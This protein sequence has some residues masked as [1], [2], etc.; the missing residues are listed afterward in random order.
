[1]N[2]WTIKEI[3]SAL[4]LKH[5]ENKILF[6]G[7]SIDS[8]TIKKGNLYIPLKGNNFDGHDFIENAFENGASA[9]LT[10]YYPKKNDSKKPLI[11][12]KNN[13][14][15]LIE[16]A[17]YSRKRIKN[18]ITVC[19]TGSSGKTTLKEWIYEI[20][21]TS[22]ISYCTIGNFNNEIG[23]PLSL[24]NMPKNTELCILELG[25]N[26]P[27][28]I[29]K[30]SK[31]ANPN[32]SI[33]TNIGSAHAENFKKLEEIAFEKSEIFTFL[34]EKSI[35]IIPRDSEF[36]DLINKKALKK[37]KKVFSFGKKDNCHFKIEDNLESK[38]SEFRIFN[39]FIK[40]ENKSSFIN[41]ERNIVVILG[42][43][44]LLKIRIND[45][46]PKIKNLKPIKGRGQI[47]KIKFNDKLFN[48]I[49]ESYN[50]NPESLNSALENLANFNSG[51]SRKICIIGDM[52]E[53]GKLSAKHHLNVV[54]TIMKIKP[55]IV[56]TVGNHTRMIF[57]NLPDYFQKFHYQDYK[58]VFRK[59]LSLI[60]NNDIIMIKGSNS[61]N[62]HL[63]TKKLNE[64][65]K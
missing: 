33:I 56:I 62:L 31:I 19:V 28:E 46:I 44:E 50:S 4:R 22:K 29:R 51:F 8:R 20:F 55:E 43:A 65:G 41:W 40:I 64:L 12:V 32:I 5:N 23:M 27:G 21:K 54:K 18:L 2:N 49:D 26:S 35:A 14:K 59:L 47:K 34:D 61:M 7:V 42:L 53:L 60:K 38:F 39:E 58:K 52:L 30:L 10:E 25:M 15:A 3:Y 36:F 13:H 1:M 48:I 11:F 37:T 9:S 45:L 24:A 57:E 17:K 63:V 6:S 16:L